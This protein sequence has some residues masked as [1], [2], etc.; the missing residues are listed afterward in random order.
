MR[1]GFLVRKMPMP[2]ETLAGTPIWRSQCG[3]SLLEV[4]ITL[5]LVAILASV[6]L[7]IAEVKVARE[8]ENEL[9]YALMA[10]RKGIDDFREANGTAPGASSLDDKPGR[11]ADPAQGSGSPSGNDEAP[12]APGGSGSGI[13][14]ATVETGPGASEDSG[15][16]NGVGIWHVIPGDGVDNDSDGRIDEEIADGR[17]NDGDGMTDEDLVP[18]GYPASLIDMVRNHKLRKLF[19][20]PMGGKWQYRPSTG[21]PDSW[22]DFIGAEFRAQPGDDIYDVRTNSPKK[23]LNGSRYDQW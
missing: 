22:K 17:D 18:R 21:P 3:L 4:L 14:G 12:A 13:D 9:K 10:M 1:A 23:G 7:P 11:S 16:A 2:A 20:E 19:E 5:S 8:R 6:G 15:V